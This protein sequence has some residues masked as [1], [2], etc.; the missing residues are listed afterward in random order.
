[1]FKWLTQANVFEDLLEQLD[2]L[3]HHHSGPATGFV[4]I[5]IYTF[6]QAIACQDLEPYLRY[7]TLRKDHRLRVMALPG[8]LRHRWNGVAPAKRF[9]H[10]SVPELVQNDQEDRLLTMISFS[11]QSEE[12]CTQF[13][14]GSPRSFAEWAKRMIMR[15]QSIG[16]VPF[17]VDAN[18]QS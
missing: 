16:I 14:E 12:N 17:E 11:A 9:V 2:M 3:D 1:M 7:M 13:C 5:A 8:P 15:G 18:K 6:W 4:N 10:G